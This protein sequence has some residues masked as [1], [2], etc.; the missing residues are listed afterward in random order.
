MGAAVVYTKVSS[1]IIEPPAWT[2]EC[3]SKIGKTSKALLI[4]LID[5]ASRQT[6]NR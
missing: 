5:W 6:A 4:G 2:D 3:A 1:S